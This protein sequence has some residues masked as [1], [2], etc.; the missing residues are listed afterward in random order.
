MVK[1]KM[2]TKAQADEAKKVDIL[3]EIHPVQTKFEG[4]K[5][6]YFVLSAK[7]QLEEKYGSATV[8]RGG[9]KVTTTLD[10]NL[11]NLA[12]Q[13]VSKGMKQIIKQGGDAAAFVAV[14][15]QTAQ[16][17]ALVGGPDFTNP[18]YGQVNF[19]K[20][21]L[22]PGSSFKPYDFTALIDNTNAGA[23]SV[24]YDARGALPGYPCTNQNLPKNGGN[25]LYDYDFRFPGPVTLRYALGGSRNIPAIK[26]MLMADGG[27]GQGLGGINKT[28]ATA[29]GLGLTSGYK[30]Y[31]DDTLTKETQC[32][33]SSAIGDG[34]Y[35]R[36]DEHVNG[37]APV[38]KSSMNGS[39]LSQ[40]RS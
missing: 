20:E 35:L 39:R 24:I 10:L 6:P 7:Q 19:A 21:K 22:P 37:Y 5:A 31:L 29:E 16:I 36:L 26:A 12:E 2:V 33:A 11:Q 38:A 3:S 9:W 15:V 18:V 4:I 40:S 17:V 27:N 1:Q 30:C 25:C 23:G 28:I 8:Q 34:A 14:D 32:Y 13:Q